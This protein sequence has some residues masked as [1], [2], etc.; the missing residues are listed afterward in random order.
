MLTS[1][2]QEAQAGRYG[3]IRRP[4]G[5]TTEEVH[6]ALEL[7]DPPQVHAGILTPRA[8]LHAVDKAYGL[9][10]PEPR[11]LRTTPTPAVGVPRPARV[12]PANKLPDICPGL[13]ISSSKVQSTRSVQPVVCNM[14]CPLIVQSP[15]P[16]RRRHHPALVTRQPSTVQHHILPRRSVSNPLRQAAQEAHSRRYKPLAL[17]KSV[18]PH[19]PSSIRSILKKRCIRTENSV[20]GGLHAEVSHLTH[21]PAHNQK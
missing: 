19:G 10:L 6:A 14:T 1:C 20:H 17:K 8:W 21:T 2:P 18:H 16:P 3:N 5:V 9:A 11:P 12:I 13:R 7:D 15:G 4:T